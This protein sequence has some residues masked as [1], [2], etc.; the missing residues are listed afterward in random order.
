[1]LKFSKNESEHYFVAGSKKKKS[2]R[3]WRKADGAI[4]HH[5]AKKFEFKYVVS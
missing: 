2:E 1:M 4:A 3:K 5:Y